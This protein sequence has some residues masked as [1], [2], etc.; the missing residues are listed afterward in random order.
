MNVR[1][2]DDEGNLWFVSADDSHKNKELAQDP[3]VKLNFQ[4]SPH[5]DFLQL[6]GHATISR[7]EPKIK[8]TLGARDQDL[9]YGRR[10]R[11]SH[12]RHQGDSLGRL[13]LGQQARKRGGGPQ[14][15][16]RCDDRKDPRRLHRG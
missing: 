15:D 11:S 3:S 9:V 6:T 1:Q 2:V 14:N 10:G 13:L 4:G 16:D 5:S 8:E 12:H 7:D